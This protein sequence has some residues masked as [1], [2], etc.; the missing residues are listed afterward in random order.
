MAQ[1]L[2]S[3]RGF[4]PSP[5]S[6]DYGV[7]RCCYSN[8]S[9]V[10]PRKKSHVTSLFSISPSYIAVTSSLGPLKGLRVSFGREGLEQNRDRG[11][12]HGR[13]QQTWKPVSGLFGPLIR[14]SFSMVVSSYPFLLP[15][16]LLG[17]YFLLCLKGHCST[18]GTTCDSI[19]FSLCRIGRRCYSRSP[20]LASSSYHAAVSSSSLPPPSQDDKM[21][22]SRTSST[23]S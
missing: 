16:C 5:R 8:R 13:V 22:K 20:Q 4:T 10:M 9:H 12:R 21:H 11:S 2:S 14:D 23:L 3:V 6:G 19:L 18:A 15:K 17:M 7:S 1:P